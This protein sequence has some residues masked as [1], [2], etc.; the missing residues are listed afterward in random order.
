M[1][2]LATRKSCD[3]TGNRALLLEIDPKRHSS[4]ID[5]VIEHINIWKTN[6]LSLV[7]VLDPSLEAY[8]Q[9]RAAVKD[10]KT[11]SLEEVSRCD[12]EHS[13]HECCSCAARPKAT[14]ACWSRERDRPFSETFVRAILA[15]H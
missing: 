5:T 8:P 15:C 2:A 11:S 12:S 13:E 6:D 9:L 7:L 4:L 14:A 3:Q 10:W 1:C